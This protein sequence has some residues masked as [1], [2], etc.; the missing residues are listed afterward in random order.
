MIGTLTVPEGKVWKIIGW[1]SLNGSNAS[2]NLLD[3]QGGAGIYIGGFNIG[4]GSYGD[5]SCYFN[6]GDY[7]L[8]VLTSSGNVEGT[9][10]IIEY[11]SN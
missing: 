9:L 11:N 1:E 4:P 2:G 6:S 10:K 3:I 5:S 7:P 8:W